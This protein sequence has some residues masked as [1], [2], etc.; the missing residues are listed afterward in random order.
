MI[1][2]TIKSYYVLYEGV[3][4]IKNDTIEISLA[5]GYK[6]FIDNNGDKGILVGLINSNGYT[7]SDKILMGEQLKL[8]REVIA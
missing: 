1:C 3:F 8:L 6:I 2:I 5:N 4:K 7:V